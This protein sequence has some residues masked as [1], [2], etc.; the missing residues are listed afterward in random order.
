MVSHPQLDAL[1]DPSPEVRAHLDRCPRCRVDVRLARAPDKSPRLRRVRS[2]LQRA[3]R[4][5][6]QR[7]APEPDGEVELVH[8]LVLDGRYRVGRLLGRGGMGAVYEVTHLRLGTAFALKTLR[9]AD[10]ALHER[11]EEEG[12]ILARL[13]HPNLVVVTDLIDVG[14]TPAVV[15][16]LVRG[17]PL[18]RLLREGALS[19]TEI[20]A[21]GGDILD[22]V[23]A[24]H[25]AGL[26]HRDLKPA[27]VLVEETAGGRGAK[28]ADFGLAAVA[29][30]GGGEGYAVGTPG[31]AAPE[32]LDGAHVDARADV[33]ALGALLYEMVA[34]RRA[35]PGLDLD[36]VFER[37][38]TG[39]V[40]PLAEDVPARM[41][42]A[43]TRA[44]QPAAEDR[45]VDAEALAAI[46]RGVPHSAPPAPDLPPERDPFVGRADDLAALDRRLQA[47]GRLVSLLGP[48]GVGKT[49]LALHYARSSQRAWP[50]GVYFCGLAE[51][52][53][54]DGIHDAVADALGV[55]LG[56]SDADARLGHAIA[57]RGRCLLVL[58]N[59][60]Q[61]VQHAHATVQRWVAQT[62][63]AV[64]LV[65]SRFLLGVPGEIGLRLNPLGRDEA[66]ALFE[67]RAASAM[68]R[69]LSPVDRT[70]VG[71][72]V[73]LL[74]HLP[75]A[76]ELAAARAAV[77]PVAR[78][79]Q[80]LDQ[81]FRL[82]AHPDQ[83]AGRHRSLEAALAW[84]W[85]LLEPHARRALAQLAVFEGGFT[86]DAADAVVALDAGAPW[87]LDVVQGLVNRS[88]V[89]RIDADRLGMLVSV[90]E[91]AQKRDGDREATLR[92]HM[93]WFARL[94]R[95]EACWARRRTDDGG[96]EFVEL[97]NLERA[98]ATA[99]A[100][101]DCAHAALTALAIGDL[102]A[103]RGSG[104]RAA[105]L[106][107]DALAL[108]GHLAVDTA[109]L[110]AALGSSRFNGG[111]T[112]EALDLLTTAVAAAEA[113]GDE[114][115]A[116]ETLQHVALCESTLGHSDR[117]IE[118]AET[119]L[120]R[121][122]AM[123]DRGLEAVA[124]ARLG[125]L[126]Y[127]SGDV[128]GS[129]PLLQ[130]ALQMLRDTGD[131]RME[132]VFGHQL[133][134]VYLVTGQHDRARET[135]G[136]TLEIA[137][138]RGNR[139]LEASTLSSL[140]NLAR[141]TGAL[142]EAAIRYEASLAISRQIGS[143][144]NQ[145]TAL[146]NLGNLRMRQRRGSEALALLERALA[147]HREVGD[148]PWM[149]FVLGGL[150]DLHAQEGR[151][152]RAV[153][154]F[155]QALAVY[156]EIGNVFYEG[157]ALGSIGSM[158][159]ETGDL[160]SAE[161]MLT[162]ALALQRKSANRVTEGITL[163][164][165]AELADLMGDSDAA[166]RNLAD[167]MAIHREVGNRGHAAHTLLL[168]ASFELRHG[169][170]AS[171]ERRIAEALPLARE[172]GS[173]MVELALLSTLAVAES[174]R[175]D[176]AS[177]L[178]RVQ[179]AA[180]GMRALQDPVCLAL[181]LVDLAEVL[182]R[183]APVSSDDRL[184]A[185]LALEEAHA[186]ARANGLLPTSAL[187]S[188]LTEVRSLVG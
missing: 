157:E 162:A 183:G 135:Y 55:P 45:P 54:A 153:E 72:L 71:Q 108:H 60:E 44:L 48:G 98:F 130:D 174:R 113:A 91:F 179:R 102:H 154:C 114:Q 1:L 171:A 151:R 165:M 30:H 139:G 144:R 68:G 109:R 85:D 42:E 14:G 36:Q 32:Q 123:G 142:D 43:I 8:G 155:E 53:D 111:D 18:D 38:R 20:D 140:G 133:A 49:R 156:R 27:N 182:L 70:A 173:P 77:L 152:A 117:A 187:G 159:L 124:R 147:I 39:Q 19:L 131:R 31:Y 52:Q 15:T 106:L 163:G 101:G 74:D 78:I 141:D 148:R 99:S 138:A 95:Q 161:Q 7:F 80:R 175:G 116:C 34:G 160:E 89:R 50:G 47:E 177:G 137:R 13:R 170:E 122:M 3:S 93:Q 16:E 149:G 172:V 29:V 37:T 118:V 188:R 146:S 164:C 33:F 66:I 143:R 100:S 87:I 134:N 132:A 28:V 22:G 75:L 115:L 84:S 129:Q 17:P 178:E 127:R 125:D 126:H 120:A 105:G 169:R 136:R 67:A 90:R 59:F 5:G 26:V 150:G 103:G 6:R 104:A 110:T 145:G 4:Q 25:R 56:G 121:A 180:T 57:A 41:R 167:S 79:V 76:I 186:I 97:D 11:L 65:T 168:W 119:A 94:G 82:L 64:F 24:V 73:D 107:A 51:A 40:R 2:S 21:L 158:H 184:S 166:A 58:D 69:A 9:Q 81:R 83:P 96:V 88:L 63:E 185:A 86:L 128:T 23:A 46:W 10:R 92:R 61:V 12:R 176:R 62:E 35:F 181:V 112:A